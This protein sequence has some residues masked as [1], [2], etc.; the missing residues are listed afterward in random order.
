MATKLW[1]VMLILITTFLTSTAQ[2]FYKIGSSTLSANLFEIITNYYLISGLFI[3]AVGAI[4]MIVSFRGGEV[5]VL[6]PIVAMSYIW[7]TLL[8]A[9]FLGE[10]V[11]SFKIV[12]VMSIIGGIVLIGLGSKDSAPEAML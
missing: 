4:L 10:K 5:S 7:V 11:N 2:I 8:S 9:G 1:A 6:Y 12:G 3:Y